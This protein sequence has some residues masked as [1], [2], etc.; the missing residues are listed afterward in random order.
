MLNF[1]FSKITTFLSLIVLGLFMF[2][3]VYAGTPSGADTFQL[4]TDKVTGGDNTGDGGTGAPGDLN[5]YYVGQSFNTTF[6]IVSGG[7]SAANIW[8][9]YNSVTTTAS[10]LSTGSYFTTWSGQTLNANARGT[11]L[12]RVYSTG[13]NIPVSQS[14]GSGNFGSISWLMNRPSAAN[15][16]ESTPETLDINVGTIGLTTESNISLSGVDLLD[17]EEDFQIHIWADTKKPFAENPSPASA[18]TGVVVDANYSFD[19]RDTKNG[20]GDNTGV[21]TG[22]D[23]TEPPGF[24]LFDDG[25]GDAD[26]T[27]YDSFSCS[28]IWGTNYCATTVNPG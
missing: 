19:L 5:Y 22:V 23:T 16:G 1:Q 25:D 13:A 21:G 20:E 6:E 28:G 8:I 10:N 12:G 3:V 7:T 2:Q 18:G 17:D 24:I 14:T 9:D 26:Y 11:G 27:S 15:Y 4:L